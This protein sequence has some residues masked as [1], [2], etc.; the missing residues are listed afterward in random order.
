MPPVETPPNR[1]LPAR[2]AELVV[3]Q[4]G[5]GDNYVVKDPLTGAYYQLGAEEHFLLMQLDGA[6]SAPAIAAAFADRFGQALDARELDE[7][8]ALAQTQGFLSAEAAVPSAPRGARPPT[9]PRANQSIL[10]WRKKFWDPD[11]CFT[12]LAPKLWFFWT[13]TFLVLSACCILAAGL[14]LATS[15]EQVASS[16]VQALRW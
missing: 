14:V 11:R 13:R 1:E 7:F 6:H 2:R 15:P 16:F 5:D 9:P 10:Y 12:W 8:V 4:L 3:G